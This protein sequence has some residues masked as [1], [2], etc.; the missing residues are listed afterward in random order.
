MRAQQHPGEREISGYLEPLRRGFGND[1]SVCFVCV[2]T[3]ELL[4]QQLNIHLESCVNLILSI[5]LVM[6]K[7]NIRNTVA[8]TTT[9]TLP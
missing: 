9:Y 3:L 7:R 5:F 4:Q 1:I 6:I 8:A 2:N